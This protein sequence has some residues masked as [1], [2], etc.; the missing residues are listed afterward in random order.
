MNHLK[1]FFLDPYGDPDVLVIGVAL[2]LL[3]VAG[4]GLMLKFTNWLHRREEA[5]RE[6]R[7]R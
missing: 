1:H 3:A 5:R 2:C 7:A 6:R 4:A